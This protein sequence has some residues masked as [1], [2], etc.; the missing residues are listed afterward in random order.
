M[1]PP[2][3]LICLLAPTVW[4]NNTLSCVSMRAWCGVVVLMSRCVCGG[5]LR[6]KSSTDLEFFWSLSFSPGW[7]RAVFGNQKSGAEGLVQVAKACTIGSLCLLR[8]RCRVLIKIWGGINDICAQGCQAK[9][10]KNAI[11]KSQG[12]GVGCRCR[13]TVLRQRSKFTFLIKGFRPF[14]SM[15]DVPGGAS[16]R[17][18]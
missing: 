10:P 17:E 5:E 18:R 6:G 13:R 11:L 8:S 14:G 1:C 7:L 12:K 16:N 9:K 2:Q 4:A 15:M 3:C